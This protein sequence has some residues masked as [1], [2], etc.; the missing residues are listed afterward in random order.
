M[1]IIEYPSIPMFIHEYP[2]IS[3]KNP[4]VLIG[5]LFFACIHT[6]CHPFL[7][8]YVRYVWCYLSCM[9][10]ICLY[11]RV[12]GCVCDCIYIC[13]YVCMDAYVY[14]Y[15]CVYIYICICICICIYIC[16]YIYICTDVYVY[17]HV[18]GVILLSRS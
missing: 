7:V 6:I 1:N 11:L 4:S 9:V 5:F 12:C 16:M 10:C 18:W 14:I 17:V 8:T 13:M 15:T 3:I 2:Q